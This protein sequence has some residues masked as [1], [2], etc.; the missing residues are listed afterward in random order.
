V[1]L[2]NGRLE[3]L[4]VRPLLVHPVALATNERTLLTVLRKSKISQRRVCSL[5]E[6]NH[7]ILVGVLT[8][9]RAET[10][11]GLNGAERT[12][13]SIIRRVGRADK[14]LGNSLSKGKSIHLVIDAI[15]CAND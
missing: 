8:T 4:P 9:E 15:C 6:G 5:R 3:E 14:T 11:V 2:V 7:D 10:P 13:V 12:V 1:R